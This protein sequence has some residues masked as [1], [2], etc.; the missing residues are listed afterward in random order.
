MYSII[1]GVLCWFCDTGE[2]CVALRAVAAEGSCPFSV[3]LSHHGEE[4]GNM[5]GRLALTGASGERRP[6]RSRI[7]GILWECFTGKML[8]QSK[9]NLVEINE[10]I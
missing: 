3:L 9:N 4:T 5:R 10:K 6:T 7:Y 2:C 1:P 8:R